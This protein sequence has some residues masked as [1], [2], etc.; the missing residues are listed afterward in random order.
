MAFF[1]H[2]YVRIV[3]EKYSDEKLTGEVGI[4]WINARG[5]RTVLDGFKER[6]KELQ[7]REYARSLEL[8]YPE[9]A[10]LLS[11]IADYYGWEAKQ[12]KLNS[13]SFPQ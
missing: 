5:V 11:I 8:D 7:Y 13:E 10:K 12:D 6:E 1:P 4:G 3:L 9:T 2:E